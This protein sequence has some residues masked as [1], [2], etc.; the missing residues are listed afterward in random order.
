M[1]EDK[2]SRQGVSIRGL[3]KMHIRDLYD[4]FK[5]MTGLILSKTWENKIEFEAQVADESDMMQIMSYS[6]RMLTTGLTL[7]FSRFVCKCLTEKSLN[8]F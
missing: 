1:E 5:R 7:N 6:G 3:G 8:G 4:I 2:R